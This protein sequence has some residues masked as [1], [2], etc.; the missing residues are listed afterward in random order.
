MI[1]RLTISNFRSLGTGVVIKPG[2]LNFLVGTSGSGKSNVL[3]ALSLV[4]EAVRRGLPGAI[5]GS[6][7][8]EAVRRYSSGR[9]RNVKIDLD[10]SLA[11]GQAGYGFEITGDRSEQYRVKREWAMTRIDGQTTGFEIDGGTWQGP[12]NLRPNLDSRALAITALGGDARFKPLWEFLA[13]MMVYSVQPSVLRKPRKYS[14]QTPMQPRGDNWVSILYRQK[15]SGWQNDLVAALKK[16]TGDI[17]A[18]RVTRASGFLMTQFRHQERGEKAKKWFGVDLESDGTLRVAG[19]L[20]ALLQ[21]PPLPVIGMEEPEQAVHPGALPLIHDCLNRAASRSQVIATTHSPPLL[22]GLDFKKSR[23][24]LVQR[25]GVVTAV[26]P[27][28]EHHRRAVRD[29]LLA[30]GERAVS[31]DLQLPLFGD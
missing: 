19:L 2:R 27:L 22:D 28:S 16:L 23:V 10:I 5:A 24:F 4:R 12:G 25:E 21:K 14:S 18:V 1:T 6:G 15:K 30:L 3:L 13:N 31:G 11:G 8:I 9:P 7:G 29:H 26:Y 20:T 17:D